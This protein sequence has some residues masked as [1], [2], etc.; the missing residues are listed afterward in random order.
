[1][2]GPVEAAA[3]IDEGG[4]TEYDVSIAWSE[5][6]PAPEPPVI[7]GARVGAGAVVY[8]MVKPFDETSD[9][10]APIA[11]RGFVGTQPCS[12]PSW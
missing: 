4:Q 1:M 8:G 7:Q 12:S 10:Q 11:V 3:P 9:G 5:I 6:L 2:Y